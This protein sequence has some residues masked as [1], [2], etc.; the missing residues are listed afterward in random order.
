MQEA[1]KEVKHLWQE[2]R[3]VI[4]SQ[5]VPDSSADWLVRWAQRFARAMPGLPLRACT[6]AHV[7]AF[8]SDLAQQAH[9]ESWQVNQAQDALRVLDQECFPLPWARPWP[10]HAHAM[11]AVRGGSQG[12]SLRDEVS[13]SAV[14]A[15]HQEMLR[16]LRT[17]IRARHSSL[18][19][20]QA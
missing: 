16:R 11:E 4:S 9:V 3:A 5:G 8:L 1:T 10:F 20:E 6:Q 13:S 7:R 18:R 14:D 2:Y 12:T 17:E 19:T 15:A